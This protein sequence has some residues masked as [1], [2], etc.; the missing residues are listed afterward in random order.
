[1]KNFKNKSIWILGAS[2]GIGKALAQELASHGA[3]I[4]LSARREEKLKDVQ[5]SLT[6]D[7]HLVLPLDVTD[8]DKVS[9]YIETIIKKY[10]RI[11]STIFLA[12]IYSAHDGKAKDLSFIHKMISVNLGGAF[13]VA[14]KL[15]PV[16][17]EQGGGQ[18]ILCG[19]VAGYRGLP[20]GQ[21][22]CATKAGII[23]YAESLHVECADDNID[24]KVICPGFVETPLTDKN[25]F[26]MPMM[27]TA[28]KAAKHIAKG[29]KASA[30][31]IHFP[32]A[33]TFMLK[34]LRLLP[35]RIYFAIARR[36]IDRMEL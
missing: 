28:D 31:E 4:I 14:E 16:L 7:N 25:D 33:F 13:N 36:M 26:D 27:I 22:Y 24:V 34:I 6:G 29:M 21:P 9:E 1:M 35:D 23:S 3:H 5:D 2:S 18:L 12:A 11:D 32:K 20:N 17:K 10:G 19:S 8:A 30:F 15:R